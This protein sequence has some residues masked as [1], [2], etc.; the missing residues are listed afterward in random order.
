MS[1]AI[2]LSG[3]GRSDTD[4]PEALSNE[5]LSIHHLEKMKIIKDSN[6]V[7]SCLHITLLFSHYQLQNRRITKLLD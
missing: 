7:G 1:S 6:Q 3:R 2:L 5:K 4:L